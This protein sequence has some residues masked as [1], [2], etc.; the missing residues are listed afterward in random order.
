MSALRAT[1]STMKPRRRNTT[2]GDHASAEAQ[3]A[4]TAAAAAGGASPWLTLTD[5]GRLYGISAMH[6]G[7][8]LSEA[9]LRDRQGQPTARALDDGC[10][11]P[12]N[13]QRQ[14]GQPF[15][16]HQNCRPAFE[17]AGLVT[18][19]RATLV[20]QWADLLSALI[21]GS[22][23][24]NTSAAQMA[25]ELPGDLVEP[26][27]LQLRELGCSFQVQRP[28]RRINRSGGARSGARRDPA[29]ESP[30]RARRGAPHGAT[31]RP[32]ARAAND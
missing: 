5:L 25:E 18:V 7:R 26:V 6:C 21:E 1:V 10:A 9:G 19:Q 32:R 22:P 28:A 23:S 14:G 15:W 13:R 30:Q 12:L 31:G 8:L 27:N 11:A 20:Q 4:G 16:H 24:I 29:L 3:P 17:A 2:M